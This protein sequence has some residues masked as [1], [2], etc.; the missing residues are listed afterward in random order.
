MPDL[1]SLQSIQE[2]LKSSGTSATEVVKAY[3]KRISDHSG[4]N[5]FLE[6][7]EDEALQQARAIDNEIAA[8]EWKPLYGA[9]I[10]NK[11][12]IVQKGRK[13]SAGS[14]ILEGFE[15]L[16]DATAIQRLRKAGAI[17]IG[18]LNCDEFAMGSSNENSYYGPVKNALDEERVPGGS[19][20]GSAV[21]VQ[22]ALCTAALGTDT[23]GSVRQPAS[24]C[25]VVGLKP[26]YGRVSRYGLIAYASSF[27][28][29]GIF[30]NNVEDAAAILQVIAGHDDYDATATE[31]E[32]P[33]YLKAL[34]SDGKKRI[35]YFKEALESDALER[36][37]KD[38]FTVMVNELKAQGH[39]V[40]GINFPLL[41]YLVP[42]YYI[43]TTAE[44]SSNLA[45]YDGVHFGYR[46]KEVESIDDVY[47]K[48]RSQGFGTEVKRRILLG[49]FVLSSGYY[50]A[51]YGKG[52]QMR[53]KI[54][55]QTKDILEEYEFIL[56]P[57]TPTTAFKIG[58]KSDDPVEMYL[59]DV[60]TVH[61]NL[62]GMPAVS[63]PLG[64]H[65]NGLPFGMQLVGNYFK[66]K[67]LLGF[68]RQLM[69]HFEPMRHQALNA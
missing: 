36:E 28:Q 11:D 66:E 63:L 55:D 47:T 18:R 42:T 12:V 67:E 65:P 62:T 64:K 9:V 45:R 24:L 16:Y 26:S 54:L 37:I 22:A 20:G 7:Y 61:A 8:G 69:E 14:K 68:S 25:G 59:S 50:D 48:S 46:S 31:A 4:L 5:A 3:L 34:K 21:A 17:I 23:G 1:R 43:L 44:A 49:T 38:Q 41:Q 10:G 57:T 2:Q 51:Y 33:D 13:V 15:S 52:Q 29:I 58:E 53:R 35:A 40:E 30:S 6:V 32:V 39:E 56:S 27:D 19:S 60:Y